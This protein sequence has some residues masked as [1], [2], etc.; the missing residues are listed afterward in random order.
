M[1]MLVLGAGALGAVFGGR[2]IERGLDVT[3][4]VRPRRAEQL[5]RDG[6]VVESPAGD[7]RRSVATAA[8]AGPGF[9]AVL[10]TAKAYDL[11][12]AIDTIRPAVEAGAAVLPVLNGL[13][14]MDR[15]NAAF[16]RERV[17]GGM[18]RIVAGMTPDGVVR[19]TGEL[20]EL[21][22]G[23]QDGRMGGR[24]A[25]LAAAL[26]RGRGLE[27]IAVPDILQ[28][29]WDKLVIIGTLAGATVLFRAAI[30]DIVRAGGRDL[31]LAMLEGNAAVAAANG[32]AVSADV[33]P[34]VER[35]FAD[36]RSAAITSLLRDVE[37]GG[38]NEADHILGFLV[39]G[40]RRAGIPHELQRAA[41]LHA[42]AQDQRRLREAG[43]LA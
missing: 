5:A 28:R 12:S 6:L 35:A 29:M 3:F 26:G 19:Q 16:G 20:S 2:A 17:W 37:R 36:E 39:E 43:G 15:L 31:A 14:H 34:F 1:R 42:R 41:L 4:L 25:V 8:V 21:V 9:D 22:F 38:P 32:H 33:R 13:S 40:A 11:D 7:I 30:G 18:A 10:L 24:A 23:E 27:A